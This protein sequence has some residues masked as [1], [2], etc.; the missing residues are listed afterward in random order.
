MDVSIAAIPDEEMH[1]SLI[2]RVDGTTPHLNRWLE[3]RGALSSS[4]L[5]QLA[6][7]GLRA[8]HGAHPAQILIRP[9]PAQAGKDQKP[10]VGTRVR[11][12]LVLH[13]L[14]HP[15]LISHL[16][17]LP[18][19]LH[20]RS[21]LYAIDAGL[22]WVLN[23]WESGGSA[24]MPTAT[25]LLVNPPADAAAVMPPKHPEAPIV[26]TP[27]PAMPDVPKEP[28]LISPSISHP[29]SPAPASQQTDGLLDLGSLSNLFPSYD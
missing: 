4:V 2:L 29:A 1:L 27:I 5:A 15:L 28:E 26:P 17:A 20:R 3:E 9:L 6:E 19:E 22:E 25:A 13:P 18:V 8:G 16:Q 11:A 14:C 24:S 23:V 21:V 12:R 7:S 10:V